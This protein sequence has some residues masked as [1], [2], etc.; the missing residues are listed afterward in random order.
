[1]WKAEARKKF[2]FTV[3]QGNLSFLSKAN[4]P[5]IFFKIFIFYAINH[6]NEYGFEDMKGCNQFI[7]Q[8]QG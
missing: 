1:M 8:S 5:D 2:Y 4:N 3:I 7:Y 6:A